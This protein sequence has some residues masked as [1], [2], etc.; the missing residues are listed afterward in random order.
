MLYVH[1]LYK[2]T[3]LNSLTQSSL[4]P[5]SVVRSNPVRLGFESMMKQVLQEI[6]SGK[7]T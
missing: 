1:D 5:G 2:C 7:G 4:S 6:H 3:S